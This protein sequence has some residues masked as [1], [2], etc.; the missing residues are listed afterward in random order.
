[1]PR[2]FITPR[3][4]DFISDIT[5]ELVKDVRGQ[6]IYYYRVREDLTEVHDV[7][8]ESKEK[9]FNP[10]I[11]IEAGVEW[12]PE[13]VRTNRYGSEEIST[14]MVYLQNRDL[15]DRDIVVRE[16]DYF[17][18]GSLF[19]E[20]TSVLVDSQVYGQVEHAVGIKL[21]GKQARKG[22]IDAE[23]NGP[24]SESNTEEGSVQEEF[25][26][27]RGFAENSSGETGD[28]RQLVKDGKIDP[29][30]SKP[31]KVKKKGDDI[32]SSFYGDE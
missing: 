23:P 30:L 11:E 7:Y 5:K 2:L 10:P 27:Q 15:L 16:G 26:Q 13:E 31:S 24:T 20:I 22:Q 32:S 28:V 3:E 18:Y 21:T 19:F 6:K 25:E 4:I 8:E 9:I 29:P 14:C 17:S 12:Q 1:M